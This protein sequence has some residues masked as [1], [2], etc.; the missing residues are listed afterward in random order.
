L[1]TA[2]ALYG[3]DI[4]KFAGDALMCVFDGRERRFAEDGKKMNDELR[5]ITHLS[6]YDCILKVKKFNKLMTR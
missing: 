2:V 6:E 3:G 4:V 5:N 1:L